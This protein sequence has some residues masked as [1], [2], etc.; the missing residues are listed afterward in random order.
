MPRKFSISADNTMLAQVR[1]NLFAILS[2]NPGNTCVRISAKRSENE[3]ALCM[4][5]SEIM[6]FCFSGIRVQ[7]A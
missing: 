4:R 6:G 2:S 7:A 1:D 3:V 5:T